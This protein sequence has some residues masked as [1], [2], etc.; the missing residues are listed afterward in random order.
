MWWLMGLSYHRA[1]ARIIIQLM[2]R[3]NTAFLSA[4]PLN[5][6]SLAY[7]AGL[8]SLTQVPILFDN[9]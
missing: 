3:P 2:R 4:K 6:L 8:N 7:I 1:G 9:D 5:H